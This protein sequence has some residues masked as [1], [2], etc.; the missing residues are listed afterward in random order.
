ML[1][2]DKIGVCNK[3]SDSIYKNSNDLFYFRNFVWNK[4]I[5]SKYVP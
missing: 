5:I 2:N 1:N 3:N 4:D